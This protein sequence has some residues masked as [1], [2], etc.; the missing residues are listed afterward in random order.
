MPKIG[1]SAPD[2]ELP[3]QDGKPVKLSDYR[4]Q[5][6]V[7][8]AFTKAG[9]PGC[10]AQACALRDEFDEL[11]AADAVVLTIS[12]DSREALAHFKR[13]RNL[14]YDLLSDPEH[15]VL[16]AWGAYG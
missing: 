14:P 2:F 1:E 10:T 11:R 5:R 6:V 16:K 13:N 7:L 12:A 3:N 9:T 4:G 8:F 15:A